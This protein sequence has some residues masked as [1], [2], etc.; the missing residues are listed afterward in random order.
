ML[1]SVVS[2]EATYGM[3]LSIF[4]RSITCMF[5]I[6]YLLRVWTASD[7]KWYIFSFYGLV[8][9]ISIVPILFVWIAAGSNL[10]MI[11]SLRLLRLF[12]VFKLWRYMSASSMLRVSIKKS[13]AKITVFLVS[14]CIIV[15][16]VGTLMYVIE[17][18]AAWFDNIPTSVYRA[19][20]TI[21]TVWYGDITPVTPIGQLLSALLMILWYGIIAVPTGIVSAEI[22]AGQK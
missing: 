17:W 9:L 20:V 4:S 8:D 7:R 12:R 10:L 14:V 6:E 18:P 11:R 16:I 19:I 15:L 22:V 13:G 21:T 1:R 3:I 2:I 5:G